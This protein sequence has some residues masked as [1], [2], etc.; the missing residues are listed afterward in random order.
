M[1]RIE[2][3]FLDKEE[4]VDYALRLQDNELVLIAENQ[5]LSRD[6]YELESDHKTLSKLYIGLLIRHK[7]LQEGL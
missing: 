7:Q 5:T 2:L 3:E 4:L 1:D 6:R